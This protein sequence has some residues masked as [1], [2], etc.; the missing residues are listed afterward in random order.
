MT[1]IAD[2]YLETPVLQSALRAAPEMNVT[3][4][5]RTSRKSKPFAL[6]FW[7]SEET[8]RRSRR[9]SPT[10]RQSAT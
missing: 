8:S 9:D 5:Q 7:A 2:S 4:E 1:L 6:A 10:T 3:I